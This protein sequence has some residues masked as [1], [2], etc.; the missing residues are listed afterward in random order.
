MK[1]F[2]SL[3]L[4]ACMLFGVGAMAETAE[5]PSYTYNGS[6]TTFPTNWNPHQYKTETENTAVLA[7]ITD[8]FFEFDYNDT[9]DS[10]AMKPSMVVG[11][12]EDVTAD[13]VGDKWG[14]PEGTTARAWKYTLRNDLKWEDGTPITTADV[15][16]SMMKQLNPQAQNYRAD[17]FY[18]GSTVIHNA[19][20]YAKSGV[21]AYSSLLNADDPQYLA[22]SD[23]TVGE[24]GFYTY[25][26]ADVALSLTNKQHVVFQQPDRLLR[27]GLLL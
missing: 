9:M 10:Y 19:E 11:D 18:A 25:N 23:F 27:R 21:Y 7:Y 17:S 24:D 2:L 5:E 13:Y 20:A 4:A 16:Y 12:P 8:S 6:L 1:K 14:I 26:G 3:V 22:D 15:L